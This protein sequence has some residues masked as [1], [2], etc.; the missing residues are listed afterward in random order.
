MTLCTL[1]VYD[2]VGT[3]GLVVARAAK[4]RGAGRYPAA[5]AALGRRVH[6]QLVINAAQQSAVCN[7]LA[8]LI[9]A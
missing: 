6:N 5:R 9:R 2:S 3:V 4:R 8:A 1:G 7:I